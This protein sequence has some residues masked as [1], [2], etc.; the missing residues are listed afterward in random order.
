MV[1]GF[2][3]TKVEEV[4][5]QYSRALK[6]RRAEY[7]LSPI[8]IADVQ[9]ASKLGGSCLALLLTIHYRSVVTGR[10]VVTLPSGLMSDFGIG[11]T[12][13]GRGLKV[14]EAA[15]L[16]TVTRASGNSAR[17]KLVTRRKGNA[18]PMRSR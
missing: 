5:T 2:R 3:P 7:Y 8:R 1:H 13:K 11:R 14:L 9:A 16:I 18:P 12:V 6:T 15:K 10:D 17:V 4:E